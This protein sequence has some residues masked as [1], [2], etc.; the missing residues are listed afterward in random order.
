MVVDFQ[1]ELHLIFDSVVF[2]KNG[3]LKKLGKFKWPTNAAPWILF[4][5][6]QFGRAPGNYQKWWFAN[7]CPFPRRHFT[8][9]VPCYFFGGVGDLIFIYRILTPWN[10]TPLESK[11][12]FMPMG[13]RV[14]AGVACGCKICSFEKE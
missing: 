12:S 13:W 9:P 5:N 4:T 6:G 7:A 3:R 2:I 14:W 8:V 1:G 11:S 10:K